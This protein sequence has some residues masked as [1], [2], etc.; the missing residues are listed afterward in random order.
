MPVNVL[1]ADDDPDFRR[2]LRIRLQ[3]VGYRVHEGADG[4]GAL[5]RCQVQPD[6]IL[7]DQQMPLGDG[8]SVARLIRR[9]TDAPIVFI[10]G[11]SRE[12]FE[13]TLRDIP[14]T[15]YIPKPLCVEQLLD[16]LRRIAPTLHRTA[17]TALNA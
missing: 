9:R 2:A 8:A 4:L 17:P 15:H 16:L 1:I 10:S 12:S 13:T 5:T 6:V 3:V 11:C 14:R 7:L